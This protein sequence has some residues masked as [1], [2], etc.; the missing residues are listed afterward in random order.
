VLIIDPN[1]SNRSAFYRAMG[2]FGF[3]LTETLIAAPLD[4]GS[5]YRG[6]LLRYRRRERVTN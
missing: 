4:D 2:D 1:R 3:A 5:P 6:R